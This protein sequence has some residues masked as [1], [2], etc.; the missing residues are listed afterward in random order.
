MI[1]S[2]NKTIEYIEKAKKIHG[3]KY[4]NIRKDRFYKK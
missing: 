3:D 2:K 1:L 4:E